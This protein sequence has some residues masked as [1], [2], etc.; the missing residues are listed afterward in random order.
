MTP[1]QTFKFPL[2]AL[3]VLTV[4]TSVL[5]APPDAGSLLESVK[6]LPVL[7]A[8]GA[9]ALP[10]EAGRPPLKLDTTARIAA[11]VI[12]VSGTRAFSAAEIEALVADAAG[13]EITLAD[14]HG[15]ADRIT[16]HYRGAGYL[17][18]RAYIPAQDI[19]DGQVEIA[20]LEGRLGKLRIDNQ[21]RLADA[22]IAAYL[23]PLREDEAVDGSALERHL[24][25][26][27]D[28][29]GI[30]VKS[31]L[32]PGASV[33]ATDLDVRVGAGSPYSGSVEL[34]NF[35]NRYTG[36]QRVAGSLTIASPTGRG[37]A[38]ALRA[39]AADGMRYGRIAY[40]LPINH[41]GTQMGAAYSEMHY[42]LGQDFSDLEA[43]GTA[44]IG[45]LYLLHPFLRSRSANINGQLSYDHK[46]LDDRID[47]SGTKTAKRLAVW[48]L[49]ISGNRIDGLGGGGQSVW[50][51]AYVGGRLHLD[52]DSAS[53]DAA[54]HRTA[55]AY[56]KFTLNL[57]RQQSLFGDLSLYANVQ[58]QHA[59]KNL[60]SSEKMILGGAQA[61]RA[62]PQGEAPADDAWLATL[63]L[64][65]APTAN[66]QVSLF[67]DAA[68]G[69]LNHDP[70][71]ADT[72]NVRRLSGS[73]LSLAYAQP[74]S[75]SV[76]MSVAWR[77]GKEPT[78]D[79]DRNP[80]AWLQLV[81][82]F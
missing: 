32:K 7:P 4:S 20:V 23:S 42:K 43:H 59:G 15:L 11:K 79:T 26:L 35:G 70:I 30:E 22:D 10:D 55:G 58:A 54:G 67:H 18:A 17:L 75:F 53:L 24:L 76:Q 33:G 16:R 36:G 45:S 57:T 31:T 8:R 52:A 60:D 19:K 6:P 65:Y 56:G 73:G 25:L 81:K 68:E 63:E 40:Q 48:T 2:S 9:G 38:L 27:N 82:H 74:G 47:A 64:R 77:D 13:R 3:A 69:R 51:L 50:S 49:G 41:L 29:P 62:Y 12:R 5:A 14:L 80:R 37:D 72:H 21:S 78:S 44:R 61:V 66:W 46:A 71:A 39:L 34:D 28:L 1:P